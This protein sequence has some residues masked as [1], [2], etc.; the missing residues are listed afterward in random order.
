MILTVQ[1]YIIAFLIISPVFLCVKFAPVYAYEFPPYEGLTLKIEGK[2]TEKYSNNITYAQDNKNRI[3]QWTTL[4][5]L[6]LNV[7]YEGKKRALILGGQMSQPVRFDKSDIRNSSEIGT[8]D[9]VNEFSSFDKIRI[10]DI[11][12]HTR[13]PGS[14]NERDF[15][16]ECEK[17]YRE[18]GID[19][20]RNDPRCVEF[21]REFGVSQGAFDT[22]QN[23]FNLNYSRNISDQIIVSGEYTNN[24]YDSTE[25]TS[26]DSI[27]N[28]F[29]FGVNY[30]LSQTTAFFLW[31]ALSN[32][33]YDR[34]NDISTNLFRAGI[35]QYITKR[36]YFN[37]DIGMDFT[38]ITDS[39]SYNALLTGDLDEK[40]SANIHFLRDTR[41]AVDRD[42]VFRSWRV[43]GR[44]TRS[45][46]EDL[47][48]VLSAFYGEGDFV[49]AEVI[50]TLLGASVSSNYIFWQHKRGARI[51][52]N[53][54][55]R[56]SKLDSTDQSRGYDTSSIDG[57]LSLIF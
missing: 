12:T 47:I 53:L 54:G 50:D 42:D 16:E 15:R 45:L 5:T 20:T 24:K 11:Y 3:E 48:V 14:I 44:L 9:F 38:P 7:G 40:T 6:G 13:V 46:T 55:Y 2:L 19:V 29:K 22:Y 10:K 56:Y 18:Y 57:T 27:R 26:N 30:S 4:L 35:R 32:R 39:V 25:E 33:S 1:K 51:T 8:L 17:L 49:S 31:Y 23:Y 41:T 52:G 21:E 37:G 34:R 28:R 43:I 36:L